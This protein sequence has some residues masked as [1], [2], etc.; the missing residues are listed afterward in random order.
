M[1]KPVREEA[2]ACSANRSKVTVASPL[3]REIVRLPAVLS[4]IG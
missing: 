4:T 2:P 3:G 1:R